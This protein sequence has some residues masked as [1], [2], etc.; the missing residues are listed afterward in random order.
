MHQDQRRA[1]DRRKEQTR[2]WG[3]FP[4]AGWRMR[5]RRAAEH[6]RP[7]FVDR[8]SAT[9][10]LA[11]IAV[12]IFCVVDAVLTLE[13]LHRGSEE[14]NPLMGC[15]LQHGV[16]PFLVGKYVLTAVG[17]PLL[18][19]FKNYYL[20]GT[21]FRVGYLLL[22]IVALYLILITYQAILIVGCRP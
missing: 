19:I 20:F 3:A 9:L 1:P 8:F 6:C 7:Y 22:V 2:V 15:L 13:L 11:I 18:L 14:F 17:L 16:R 4:P 10:F 21:R 5:A 12:L